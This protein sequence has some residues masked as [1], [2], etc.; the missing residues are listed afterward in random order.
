MSSSGSRP[1]AKFREKLP[2]LRQIAV[3]LDAV[4]NAIF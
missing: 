1:T 2:R 4:I 3:Q